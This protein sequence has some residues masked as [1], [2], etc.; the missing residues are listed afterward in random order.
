MTM[1]WWVG[2]YVVGGVA[3]WLYGVFITRHDR[4]HKK[5]MDDNM[6]PT[7]VGTT[8]L[9]PFFWVYIAISALAVVTQRLIDKD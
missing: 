8:V 5:I 3:T 2:G 6:A 4:T 7:V 1:W 9:W